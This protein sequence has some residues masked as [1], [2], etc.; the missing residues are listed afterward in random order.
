MDR[1]ELDWLTR[2]PGAAVTVTA[3]AR[4]PFGPR[5]LILTVPVPQDPAD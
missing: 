2:T 3:T 5:E 4:N 1:L